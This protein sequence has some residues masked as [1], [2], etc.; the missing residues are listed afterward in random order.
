MV[1]CTKEAMQ[2]H[3]KIVAEDVSDVLHAV[4]ET[5]QA[6]SKIEEKR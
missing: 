3:N 5:V 2:A 1:R 4:Q 6:I